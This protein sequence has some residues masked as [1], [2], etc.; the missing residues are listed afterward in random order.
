VPD[1]E[2]LRIELAAA[3]VDA[4]VDRG[5]VAVFVVD[6]VRPTG[7]TPLAY[8][9]PDGLVAPDTV[10]VFR[11][12]APRARLSEGAHR[13]AIWRGLP[14]LPEAALGSMLRHELAHAR[15]WELSGSRF[16][17]ADDLLR[18]AV[19]AEGGR[20]YGALPSELEAN[21]AASA[22]AVRTLGGPELAQLRACADTAAL[23]EAGEPPADVVEATLAELERRDDWSPGL[24]AAERAAYVGEVRG[25]CAAWDEA[26][27]RSVVEGRGA[28]EPHVLAPV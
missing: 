14:G 24:N 23:L 11:A 6:R 25:A 8:L 17:E 20:G 9:H 10:A 18:R 13:L 27:A 28:S 22:F 5:S 21:A 2:R 7:T 26:H 19:R 15:R 3:C 1:L 4:G 16:F 12:V